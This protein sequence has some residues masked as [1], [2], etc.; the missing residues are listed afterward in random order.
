[1]RDTVGEELSARLLLHVRWSVRRYATCWLG[2]QKP[3]SGALSYRLCHNTIEKRYADQLT[4]S[5]L[6]YRRSLGNFTLLYK[7]LV[8][9]IRKPRLADILYKTTEHEHR[10]NQCPEKTSRPGVRIDRTILLHLQRKNF[11]VRVSSLVFQSPD[12]LDIINNLI[13]WPFHEEYPCC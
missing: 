12:G 9:F 13:F 7:A 4:K 11:C 8:L 6:S 2:S 1:M 3:A 5:T 10:R